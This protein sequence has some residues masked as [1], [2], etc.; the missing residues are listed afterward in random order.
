MGAG[1][2]RNRRFHLGYV[3]STLPVI[4]CVICLINGSI[5]VFMF[6][7]IRGCEDLTVYVRED[8]AGMYGIRLSRGKVST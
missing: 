6:Y 4:M 1:F 7:E 8:S 5:K 2:S 3:K